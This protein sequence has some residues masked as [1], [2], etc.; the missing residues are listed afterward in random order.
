MTNKPPWYVYIIQCADNTLYTGIT[1]DVERRIIEH[2]HDN[3]L[4]AKYTRVRR[5]VKLVHKE[6]LATR[7]LA[8]K[9]ESEI[10]KLKRVEKETL[11]SLSFA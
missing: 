9:R 5:P 10:K 8:A 2:N 11:I 6:A 3:K 7:S 4:A 1:V